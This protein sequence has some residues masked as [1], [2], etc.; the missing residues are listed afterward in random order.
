M[1]DVL[2]EAVARLGAALVLTTHDRRVA[3]RFDTAW[4]MED[5]RLMGAA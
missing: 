4:T 3:G 1:L 5:G 2:D